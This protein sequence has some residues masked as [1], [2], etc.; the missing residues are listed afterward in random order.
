MRTRKNRAESVE[1]T[2]SW[3]L[4]MRLRPKTVVVA[5]LSWIALAWMIFLAIDI[6]GWVD[7]GM[8]RPAWML[9]FNDR[10]IEWTQWFLFVF[11]IAG[12][13]YLAG[14]L[15]E[16]RQAMVAR[17]FFVFA[18]GLGLMMIEDAGD[19]R[20]VL[21]R[22][23]ERVFGS[24]IF[25]V[26]HN[27]VVEAPYFLAIAS[28]PLYALIRYGKYVWEYTTTRTYLLIGFAFYGIASVGSAVSNLAHSYVAVGAFIDIVFLGERLSPLAGRSQGFTYFLFVDSAVE[29]SIELIGITMFVAA[30][31]AF[32]HSVRKKPAVDAPKDIDK[33]ALL[34]G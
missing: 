17:F 7:F 24:E 6:Y 11:A 3:P 20:H 29:E 22:E 14:R 4:L 13:G 9:L 18:I 30:L 19:I 33:G 23:V 5:M 2:D 26:R 12:A 15:D 1:N 34:E 16:A 25:G 31:L 10:P 27:F 8:N 32:A 21:S 28:V